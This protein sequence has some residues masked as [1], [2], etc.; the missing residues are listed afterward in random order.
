MVK[1]CHGLFICS[2]FCPDHKRE[3]KS[4]GKVL[5]ILN[6]KTERG[7]QEK[8]KK[9]NDLDSSTY[10]C[11]DVKKESLL[12]LKAAVMSCLQVCQVGQSAFHFS[13]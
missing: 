2:P 5:F 7:L 13:S 9:E 1:S 11:Q 10:Y 12:L 8:R 6:G 3:R 4:A